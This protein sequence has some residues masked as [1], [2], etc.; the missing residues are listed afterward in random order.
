MVPAITSLIT[1]S[2]R[3]S[4]IANISYRDRCISHSAE[5]GWQFFDRQIKQCDRDLISSCQIITFQAE[6]WSNLQRFRSNIEIVD[7]RVSTLDRYQQVR[8]KLSANRLVTN[9]K[10][11]KSFL[12]AT[13]LYGLIIENV[14]RGSPCFRG[15]SQF[16]ADKDCWQELI[17][18]RLSTGEIRT[19][20][21]PTNSTSSCRS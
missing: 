21:C 3:L 12:L 8:A 4:S 5:A 13:K 18:N 17:I 15:L 7:F 10:T 9:Q 14:I 20:S 1:A 2:D 11:E 6:K 19:K 16:V